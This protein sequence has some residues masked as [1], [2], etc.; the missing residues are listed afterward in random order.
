MRQRFLRL[1]L[2]FAIIGPAGG[3]LALAT[4]LTASAFSCANNTQT[5]MSGT[6]IQ[7]NGSLNCTSTV[8]HIQEEVDLWRCSSMWWG[9]CITWDVMGY[10]TLENYYVPGTGTS[11]WYSGSNCNRYRTSSKGYVNGVIVAT[12]TSNEVNTPC[13]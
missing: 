2:A 11:W 6:S 3:A 1:A 5:N 7:A 4:P 13:K 9:S 8:Y 10:R 12:N